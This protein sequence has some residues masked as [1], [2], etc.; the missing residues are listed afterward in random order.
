[1]L[2][3]I[4]AKNVNQSNK[5]FISL[6]YWKNI[7]VIYIISQGVKKKTFLFNIN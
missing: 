6:S 2:K 4:H 5:N 3:F 7:L 1:M